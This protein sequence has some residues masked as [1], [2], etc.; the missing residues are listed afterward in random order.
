M[1]VY[2]KVNTHRNAFTNILVR[3][4]INSTETLVVF[5]RWAFICHKNIQCKQGLCHC[6]YVM[7]HPIIMIVKL[8][9]EI[10]KRLLHHHAVKVQHCKQSYISND[11]ATCTHVFLRHDAVKKPL[12]QQYDG[13]FKVLRRSNKHFTL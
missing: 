9:D 4:C 1:N 3:L 5:V 10:D 11:L 8:S 7:Y 6:V 13:P 12:Q 2:F